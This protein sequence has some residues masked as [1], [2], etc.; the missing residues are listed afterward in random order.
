M[1]TKTNQK[2]IKDGLAK[3]KK[4][5]HNRILNA[6]EQTAWDLLDKTRVPVLTHNLWDSIGC[7][8]FYKGVLEKMIFPPKV[9]TEK[10][11]EENVWGIDEL[12][13]KIVNPSSETLGYNGFVL[14]YVAAMPYAEEIDRRPSVTV[15]HTEIIPTT[16][17]SNLIR[18]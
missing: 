9:A 5:I 7:G 3:A 8:I 13:D 14:V 11:I 1:S 10:S 15:L 6:L 2:V 12:R 18:K 16:F 17:I 4:I